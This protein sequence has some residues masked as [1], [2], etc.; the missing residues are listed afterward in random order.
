MS[1]NGS[2]TP[3]L[4]L[5]K[6]QGRRGG[7]YRNFPISGSSRIICSIKHSIPDMRILRHVGGR[8]FGS[9]FPPPIHVVNGLEMSRGA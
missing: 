2:R 3:F 7:K 9:Q 6:V 4:D 1:D 5:K 8:D